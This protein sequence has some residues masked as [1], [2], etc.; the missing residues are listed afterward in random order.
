MAMIQYIRMENNADL[1]GHELSK[2]NFYQELLSGTPN[3]IFILSGGIKKN[4][5]GYKSPSYNEIDHAGLVTG[6]KARVIAAAEISKSFPKTI[7]VTTSSVNPN[8]P[9]HANVMTQELKRLKVPESKI[10]REEQSYDTLS[11]MVEMIKLAS[12]KEWFRIVAITSRYHIPRV[13]EMYNR[14][15]SIIPKEDAPEFYEA[16]EQL[17]KR[18]SSVKFVAAE[19]ILPHRS[20]RYKNLIAEVENTSG[21]IERVEAEKRGL[22]ALRSGNYKFR[23]RQTG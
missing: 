21:Y 10:V 1:S 8:E 18:G 6:S 23:K 22:E 5:R 17:E 9:T 14:L 19:D 13:Q 2:R 4:R 11:E 12:E 15:R 20:H 3:V 16:L 7:I